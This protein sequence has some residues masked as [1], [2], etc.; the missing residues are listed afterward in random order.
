MLQNLKEAIWP[1][2]RESTIEQIVRAYTHHAATGF[3][4][5]YMVRWQSPCSRIGSPC[6]LVD[7]CNRRGPCVTK[8]I[9]PKWTGGRQME[10]GPRLARR[11]ERVRRE[12]SR[13]KQGGKKE[14]ELRAWCNI[15][16]AL[17]PHRGIAL[18]LRSRRSRL[19][20]SMNLSRLIAFVHLPCDFHR[21]DQELTE[22]LERRTWD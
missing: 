1:P 10:E 22:N 14:N 19:M 16:W 20:V 2:M 12:R 13:M 4:H 8:C 5:N 18:C 11:G 6:R 3:H 9:D 17:R 15:A 7:W 21:N